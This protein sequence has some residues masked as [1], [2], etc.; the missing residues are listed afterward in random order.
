MPF[1]QPSHP[2]AQATILLVDDN[3]DIH[4]LVG[5]W[6]NAAGHKVLTASNAR[7]ALDIA[8]TCQV[9]VALCDVLM[10]GQ[11]GLWLADQL[12]QASPSTQIIFATGVETLD[13]RYT[14]RPGVAAYLLKPFERQD[15]LD[16]VGRVAG[17]A[18]M[19][20]EQA[21]EPDRRPGIEGW[22]DP[23][24]LLGPPFDDSSGDQ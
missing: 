4:A 5:A 8:T 12:Q 19:H 16:V 22:G 15:F 11:D 18:W 24:A 10:P 17:S 21:R 13:A 23:Q 14:L 3:M 2:P 20:R 9:D 1:T 6:L 7:E